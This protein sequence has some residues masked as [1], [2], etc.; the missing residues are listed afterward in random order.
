MAK[1]PLKK[2]LAKAWHKLLVKLKLKKDKKVKAG[3]HLRAAIAEMQE[4]KGRRK[5]KP[6][7]AEDHF[8]AAIVQYKEELRQEDAERKEAD[9]IEIET[10]TWNRYW[11]SMEVEHQPIRIHAHGSDTLAFE[12]QDATATS[13]PKVPLRGQTEEEYGRTS[14][15]NIDEA[16]Y[17]SPENENTDLSLQR[18]MRFAKPVALPA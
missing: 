6:V 8:R 4:E 1:K 5:E 18:L 15:L 16:I 9:R 14:A 3:T 7:K 12:Q 11:D 17:S 10:N 2:K 13:P